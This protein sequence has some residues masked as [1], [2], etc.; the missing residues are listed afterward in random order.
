MTK[1]NWKKQRPRDMRHA[2]E[3]NLEHAL[4]VHRRNVDRVAELMGMPSKW[5]LYRWVES[6]RIPAIEIPSFEH[7]C[8]STYVT[9]YL[10][11]AAHKLLVDIPAGKSIGAGGI[12]VLQECYA[13]ATGVLSKFY[14]GKATT[15][16]TLD[17]LDQVMRGTAWHRV[18]VA[19]Q[20]APEL[21]LFH[22]DEA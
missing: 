2:M 21:G 12:A 8:G 4:E 14:R 20:D 1:R 11:G 3:L 9:Q 18:N 5:T 10:A 17:A 15:E 22:E 16:E 13:A 6:G 19:K 7:A